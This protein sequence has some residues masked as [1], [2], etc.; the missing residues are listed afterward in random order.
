MSVRPGRLGRTRRALALWGGLACGSALAWPGADARAQGLA[1]RVIE[2]RTGVPVPL[3]GVYLLD[4]DGDVVRRTLADEEGRFV[5]EVPRAGEYYIRVE[6][7]GYR[8]LTSL[9]LG[10]EEERDYGLDL[11]IRPEA[12]LIDPLEVTVSNEAAVRRFRTLIGSDPAAL[13]GA[14][15]QGAELER[16]KGPDRDMASILRQ[17]NLPASVSAAVEGICVR[18]RGS[19]ARVYFDGVLLPHAVVETIDPFALGAVVFLTAS[20]AATILGTS[21][22]RSGSGGGALLL[23]TKGFLSTSRR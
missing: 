15:V 23:F 9:L 8:I 10:I 22:E 17:A 13:G 4:R 6:R 3:S 14:V 1:G 2:E 11:E 20:E 12:I 16:L 18:A 5:L 21:D 19:C 7:F